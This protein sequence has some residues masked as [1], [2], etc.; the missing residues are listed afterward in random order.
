MDHA[1]EPSDRCLQCRAA[2]KKE[3]TGFKEPDF[4]EDCKNWIFDPMW[5][6]RGFWQDRNERKHLAHL[7]RPRVSYF[8]SHQIV[9]SL[10]F[11]IYGKL[12]F[13]CTRNGAQNPPFCPWS[14]QDTFIIYSSIS[15]QPIF[16]NILQKEKSRESEIQ[17]SRF[18]NRFLAFCSQS[19]VSNK[20]VSMRIMNFLLLM[21]SG[22]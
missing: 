19:L 9:E 15:H 12:E 22:C 17:K 11:K 7:Y 13:Q 5:Q 3:K 10:I 18:T 6:L 21:T 2:S 4:K 1:L 20:F 16:R 14:L 8:L